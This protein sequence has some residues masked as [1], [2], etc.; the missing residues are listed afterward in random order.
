MYVGYNKGIKT[1]VD[2]ELKNK[3][4]AKRN[5][6]FGTLE[7]K[8]FVVGIYYLNTGQNGVGFRTQSGYLV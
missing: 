3:E 5:R 1:G 6:Q 8:S 7:Q 4:F 2:H